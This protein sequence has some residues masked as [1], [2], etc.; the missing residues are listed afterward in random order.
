M[1]V[2]AY[3][4]IVVIRCGVYLSHTQT[5]FLDLFYEF[6]NLFVYALEHLQ[7]VPDR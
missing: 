7:A 3:L 2:G 4:A 6:R 5:S 1:D